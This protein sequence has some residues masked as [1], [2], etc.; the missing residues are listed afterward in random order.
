MKK[1]SSILVLTAILALF[2]AVVWSPDVQAQ[3]SS[4]GMEPVDAA[5]PAVHVIGTLI[6]DTTAVKPGQPFKL[7]VKLNMQPGWHT[8]YKE[9]GDAGL[10]TKITWELPEGFKAGEL[11]WEKPSKFIES[12]IVTYGYQNQTVIAAEVTPPANLDASKPLKFSAKV[13][14][15]SCKDICLPGSTT[16]ELTLPV[17]ADGSGSKP[18]HEKE[19]AGL[20]DRGFQGDVK[21]LKEDAGAENHPDHTSQTG[22]TNTSGKASQVPRPDPGTPGTGQAA[23]S[24]SILDQT[25]QI[26][27]SAAQSQSLLTYLAMAFVGGLILNIMPCVLPVIA[28]KVLSILEQAHDEPKKVRLLGLTF[29]AGIISSFMLLAVVAIALKATGQ[30]VGWGFQMKSPI[31]VIA[32]SSLVLV[33]ALSLFGLFYVNVG[34]SS[35]DKLASKEGLSGTF[36]KGVLATVLST[37]CTAPYLGTAVGFA[38]VQPPY[39]VALIFFMSALGMASPYLVLTIKPEWMKFMPKPGTWMEKFKESLGFILLATVVWLLGVLGSEVG[40]SAVTAT[41]FFLV[42]LSFACWIVSKYTDLSSTGKRKA[43]VWTIATGITGAAFYQFVWPLPGVGIPLESLHP[44]ASAAGKGQI[45]WQPFTPEAL[46]KAVSEN[47]T[48]LLDF[49]A[50]W[51]LTCKVNE[52][53]VLESAPVQ[54]RLRALHVVTMQADWTLQDEKI[55]ALLQKF[56]RSGVPLY[57]IFPAGRA[58]HPIVLPEV[59]TRD[60]VVEKLNEAGPSQ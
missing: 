34:A 8:Y 57:V 42:V 52:S 56:N 38:F 16:V 31:V 7:G 20:G 30:S 28:I 3:D 4:F 27:G 46:N 12:N 58:T 1:L 10:P 54:E 51:C 13:R 6:A 36:F 33:F 21:D 45:E 22:Q 11:L 37:P 44:Q 60:M 18:D 59:I 25:F 19:F 9:S 53:T 47:K 32:M 15:L 14:W 40:S 2:S 26:E 41:S 23:S 35:I 48:V 49:T 43:I 5:E 29:A 39:V 50:N 17:S 24:G 55:T